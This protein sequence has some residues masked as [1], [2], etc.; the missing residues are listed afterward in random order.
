VLQRSRDAAESRADRLQQ[1]DP[2]DHVH[3][4]LMDVYEER[5]AQDLRWGVQNHPDGTGGQHFAGMAAAARAACDRRHR[6]GVG[7][8]ADILAEETFEAFAETDPQ[9]LR[10]E[11][12]QVAAV[13]V[14]WI[15][16]IDRTVTS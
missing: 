3:D 6:A 1:A 7:T 4:V 12:V 8:W 13:A 2:S 16:C 9:L 10:A 5:A 15:E 14:A 11:L